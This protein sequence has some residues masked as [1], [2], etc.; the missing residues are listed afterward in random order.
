MRYEG[1]GI[2]RHDAQKLDEA[3]Y[4]FR[5]MDSGGTDGVIWSLQGDLP[6]IPERLSLWLADKVHFI[7]VNLIFV[8]YDQ[9]RR[10]FQ[11]RLNVSPNQTRD[12]NNLMSSR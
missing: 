1:Y 8:G 3:D 5:L 9:R 6:L 10:R 2:L 7:D 4:D 12:P 11:Y